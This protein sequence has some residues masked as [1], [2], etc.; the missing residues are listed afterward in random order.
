MITLQ[1]AQPGKELGAEYNFTEAEVADSGT[2][3][4]AA[5]AFWQ[6]TPTQSNYVGPLVAKTMGDAADVTSAPQW[7]SWNDRRNR[8]TC[9]R[10]FFQP[11][12][13]RKGPQTAVCSWQLG[14]KVLQTN[15]SLLRE[16]IC[17]WFPWCQTERLKPALGLQL[18]KTSLTPYQLLALSRIQREVVSV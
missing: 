12:S 5:W 18:G 1:R 16:E 10:C 11:F 4:A 2:H 9:G 17:G 6:Q 15:S 7:A 14:W 13:T 8:E 3:P